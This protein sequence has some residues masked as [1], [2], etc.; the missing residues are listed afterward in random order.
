MIVGKGDLRDIDIV[1]S[2]KMDTVNMPAPQ[3]P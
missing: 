1:T 3:S 2:V